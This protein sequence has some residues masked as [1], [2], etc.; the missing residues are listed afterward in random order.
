MD[1]YEFDLV[2]SSLSHED[3]TLED[4]LYEAGCDDATLCFRNSVAYLDFTRES[5]SLIKAITSAIID[6]ENAGVTI[7]RVMPDNI[8]SAS[9][10][11]RR[12]DRSRESIRTLIEGKRGPGGF[13]A[14]ISGMTN[15]SLL[16]SWV[17]VTK[18]LSDNELI[19]RTVFEASIEIEAVNTALSERRNRELETL[20][21]ETLS[22]IDRHIA[23]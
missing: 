3:E 6:A 15:K 17:D 11:S 14:P 2:L 21:T 4:R 23:A 9:D 7:A 5:D 13:P 10:I 20:K 18:W 22:K 12:I 8:V 19:S 1:E 16:W